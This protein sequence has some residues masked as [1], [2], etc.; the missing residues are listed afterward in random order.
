[1]L[2]AVFLMTFSDFF[3]FN[4]QDF[5]YFIIVFVEYLLS[6]WFGVYVIMIAPISIVLFL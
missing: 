4:I 2:N 1:M 5:E 3:I 6:A